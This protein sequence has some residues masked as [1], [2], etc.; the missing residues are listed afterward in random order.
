VKLS[1]NSTNTNGNLQFLTQNKT[2][3]WILPDGKISI[4][5]DGKVANGYLLNIKG[6]AIAEEVLVELNGSWPDYVFAK[7]YKLMSFSQLR[8]YVSTNNHLPQIPAAAEMKDGIALG[9]MNKL[10][11]EKVE[12]LTLYILQLHDEIEQLKKKVQ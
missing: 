2:R 7:D 12:E 5:D 9:N 4:S 10:L 11:T 8:E 6:K 3:L 1:V